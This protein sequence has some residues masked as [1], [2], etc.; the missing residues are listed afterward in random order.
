M[1]C[2]DSLVDTFLGELWIQTEQL[3]IFF[4]LS[5]LQAKVAEKRTPNGS[6]STAGVLSPECSWKGLACATNCTTLLTFYTMGPIWQQLIRIQDGLIIKALSCTTWRYLSVRSDF[7]GGIYF[8]TFIKLIW[9]AIIIGQGK[10]EQHWCI[11]FLTWLGDC[12]GGW[13]YR[14]VKPGG[15]CLVCEGNLSACRVILL[16]CHPFPFHPWSRYLTFLIKSDR[17][18][19]VMYHNSKPR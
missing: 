15:A 1:H 9:V 5:K 13:G 11:S 18:R 10:H 12:G 8:L 14:S 4:F 7:F 16:S 6:L 19:F 3:S 17:N 2:I